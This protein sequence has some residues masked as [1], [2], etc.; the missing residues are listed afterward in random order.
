M[1][2]AAFNTTCGVNEIHAVVIVFFNPGA[3]GKNIR[4]EN[5]VFRREAKLVD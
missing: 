1:W 4:V 3:D 2:Q 5:N